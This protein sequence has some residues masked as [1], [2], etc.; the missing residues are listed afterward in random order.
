[1]R[2]LRSVEGIQYELV[3]KQVKQ[4]QSAGA[5]GRHRDGKHPFDAPVWSRLTVLCCKTPSGSG[6]PG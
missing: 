2:Q 1:M 5:A 4:L 6:I 3:R